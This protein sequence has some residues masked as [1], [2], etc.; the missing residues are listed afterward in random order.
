LPAARAELPPTFNRHGFRHA[1]GLTPLAIV[2]RSV[3]FVNGSRR[4]FATSPARQ[5]TQSVE[6]FRWNVSGDAPPG[7]L[8]VPRQR[9]L[10]AK[11]KSILRTICVLAP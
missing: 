1:P 4:A 8:Y 10:D 6:T 7:L 2:K 3:Q 5:K 11:N 9:H